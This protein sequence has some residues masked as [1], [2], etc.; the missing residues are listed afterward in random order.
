MA[1]ASA[2]YAQAWLAAAGGAGQAS[3]MAQGLT[4]QPLVPDVILL[5]QAFA[6]LSG[7]SA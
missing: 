4:M 1:A 7:Y 3:D 5:D 2:L 6:L